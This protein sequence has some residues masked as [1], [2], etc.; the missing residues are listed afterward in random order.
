MTNYARGADFERRVLK[1]M[2]AKGYIAVRAAG[3]HTP[4][5]VYCIKPWETVLV[6]CKRDGRLGPSE[7]NRFFHHC[8]KAGAVPIM[9]CAGENGGIKYYRLTAEKVGGTR[10]PMEVWDVS[11]IKG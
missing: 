5:D 2:E 10:Q 11:G 9:A 4:A 1:D 3:S 6:Q 8:Q 7:W